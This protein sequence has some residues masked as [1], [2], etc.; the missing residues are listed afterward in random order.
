MEDNELEETEDWQ[1]DFE[2]KITIMINE[3]FDSLNLG[4]KGEEE[5]E[6][7]E[8]EEITTDDVQLNELKD[9]SKATIKEMSI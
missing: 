4:C 2:K 5:T 7:P 8:C 9:K 3:R 1:Q 6:T